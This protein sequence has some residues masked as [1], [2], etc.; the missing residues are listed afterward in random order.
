MVPA[1]IAPS[2]VSSIIRPPISLPGSICRSLPAA[3]KKA[4]SLWQR[5]IQSQVKKHCL[6][7]IGL[8]QR[9]AGFLVVGISV[10]TIFGIADVL[11]HLAEVIGVLG[12]Q[13]RS[14]LRDLL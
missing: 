4:Q 10:H 2:T 14:L 1:T 5:T 3:A 6:F 13:R 11:I 12:F 8:H 7:L 9:A